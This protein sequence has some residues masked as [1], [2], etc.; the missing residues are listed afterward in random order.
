MGE[1]VDLRYHADALRILAVEPRFDPDAAD[2]ISRA[3]A[4][5]G[6]RLPAAVREWYTLAGAEELLTL[7]DNAWG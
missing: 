6:Q 3:E 1:V 5:R 7:D 2:L 4:A